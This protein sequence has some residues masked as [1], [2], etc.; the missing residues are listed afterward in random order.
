M[1]TIL[2]FS[3]LVFAYQFLVQGPLSVALKER[4]ARTEGAV[5]DAH[6]AIAEAEARAAEYDNNLHQARAEIFKMR[7]QRIKQWNAERDAAL[8]A[9]RKAAE[10]KVIQA[11]A[12]LKDEAA[13]A[14]QSIQT[15][16]GDLANQVVRAILPLTAGVPFERFHRVFPFPRPRFSDGP[17]VGVYCCRG[18]CTFPGYGPATCSHN[19]DST[20]FCNK[21]RGTNPRPPV[22]RKLQS[23]NK[24]KPNKRRP[25]FIATHQ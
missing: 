8:D 25:T 11:K 19:P 24:R 13:Y 17:V 7:E 14:R 16:A 6:R 4:R 10:Q 12:K 2:L 21:W 22:L 20:G 18:G 15:S 5:E 23:P 9:A 1:P 3:V